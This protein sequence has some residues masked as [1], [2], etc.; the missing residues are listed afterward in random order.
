M[1]ALPAVS[2]GNSGG[3]TS[4]VEAGLRST[5]PPAFRCSKKERTT[6]SLKATVAGFRRLERRPSRQSM[7]SEGMTCAGLAAYEQEELGEGVT[8]GPAS[9]FRHRLVDEGQGRARVESP[10]LNFLA[11]EDFRGQR[12]KRFIRQ[13]REP[14]RRVQRAKVG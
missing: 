1:R 2:D 12:F 9:F 3:E 8:I 5:T 11:A 6:A 13:R 10:L 7:T 4:F 14:P